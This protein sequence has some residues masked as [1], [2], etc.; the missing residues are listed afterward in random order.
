[1]TNRYRKRCSISVVIRERP[2]K[3]AKRSYVTPTRTAIINVIDHIKG[4]EDAGQLEP[5]YIWVGMQSGTAT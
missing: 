5:S 4:R 2:I 1:M 3:P